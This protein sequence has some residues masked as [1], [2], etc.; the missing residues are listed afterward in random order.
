MRRQLNIRIIQMNA[1]QSM[2]HIVAKFRENPMTR[3]MFNK[4]HKKQNSYTY[5]GK[6]SHP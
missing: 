6:N 1:H 2:I 3:T 4:I 5:N